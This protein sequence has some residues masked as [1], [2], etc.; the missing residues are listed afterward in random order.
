M[1][2]Y[3]F[4]FRYPLKN[5]VLVLPPRS[6]P[7]TFASVGLKIVFDDTTE[8][9]WQQCKRIV[10]GFMVSGFG[11]GLGRMVYF[12]LSMGLCVSMLQRV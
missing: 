7:D 9:S 4:V 10:A 6:E 11:F 1:H 2:C 5:T 3:Y 8:A 12:W